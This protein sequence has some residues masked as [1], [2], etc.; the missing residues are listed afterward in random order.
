MNKY[1]LI[2]SM[3]FLTAC[4]DVVNENIFNSCIEALNKTPNKDIG[5]ADIN[6]CKNAATTLKI[7]L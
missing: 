3:L 4:T 5:V 2:F 6:A 7:G 1:I